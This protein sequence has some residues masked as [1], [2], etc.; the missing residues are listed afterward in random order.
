MERALR[1]LENHQTISETNKRIILQYLTHLEDED[2]SLARR[3][4]HLVRLTRIA[5]TLKKDFE[6]AREE[7]VRLL[8]RNLRTRKIAP[9]NRPNHELSQRSIGDYQNTVKKFW[10]W[11]KA[12]PS[13]ETDATWN[14]PETAWMKTVTFEKNV[15]PEDILPMDRHDL[16]RLFVYAIIEGAKTRESRGL[17]SV[18]SNRLGRQTL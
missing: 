10:R 17:C 2:L 12:Q 5:E 11:L 15:L 18:P 6:S 9:T 1:H 7:D 4:T 3:V 8:I 13:R 14:P 16:H